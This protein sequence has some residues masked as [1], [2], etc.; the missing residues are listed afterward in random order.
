MAWSEVPNEHFTSALEDGERLNSKNL[1]IVLSCELYAA[2]QW[3]GNTRFMPTDEEKMGLVTVVT[4]DVCVYREDS[5]RCSSS[6]TAQPVCDE[7]TKSTT[8]K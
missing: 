7:L 8:E 5:S 2:L 4:I 3:R 6:Y 1:F